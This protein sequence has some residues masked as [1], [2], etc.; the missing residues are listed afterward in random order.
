MRLDQL[1]EPEHHPRTP[2]RV[3]GGPFGL[4]RQRG[5]HG[6]FEKRRVAQIDLPLDTA[7]IGV[8]DIALA[9]RRCG[10]SGSQDMGNGAH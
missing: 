4:R 8:E 3:G 2:L 6:G 10:S 1:L 5:L 7:I 9:S